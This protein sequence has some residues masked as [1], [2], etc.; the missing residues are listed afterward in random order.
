MNTFI[1]KR[2]WNYQT[3]SFKIVHHARYLEILEEARWAYCYENN[4][5]EPFDKQGISHVIVNINIDY[6]N[7]AAFGDLIGVDTSLFKVSQK[8]ITFRQII[9]RDNQA[10]VNAEITNVYLGGVEGTVIPVH[11]MVSFWDDLK[12]LWEN[13]SHRHDK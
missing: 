12:T 2:V 9:S 4:L 10:I 3:D 7:S 1:K 11:E 13:R 6:L 8:S 5:I